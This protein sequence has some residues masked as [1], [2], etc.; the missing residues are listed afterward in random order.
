MDKAWDTAADQHEAE[1]PAALR[2]PAFFLEA[3]YSTVVLPNHVTTREEYLKVRRLGRRR[4]QSNSSAGGLGTSSP[5]IC[6]GGAGAG[7]TDFDEIRRGY[8]SPR[9]TRGHVRGRTQRLAAV[10]ESESGKAIMCLL[11]CSWALQATLRSAA[12]SRVTFQRQSEQ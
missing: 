4:S 9:R 1:L 11:R 6:A 5:P 7:T 12:D 2:S 10:G 8:P 3:E